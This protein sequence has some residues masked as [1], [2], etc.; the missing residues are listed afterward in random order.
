MLPFE[1]FTPLGGRLQAA[2]VQRVLEKRTQAQLV[3]K[4]LVP[5]GK[6]VGLDDVGG[7]KAFGRRALDRRFGMEHD[8]VVKIRMLLRAPHD[9]QPLE[10]YAQHL[11]MA[12]ALLDRRRDAKAGVFV[13]GGEFPPLV[14]HQV[15]GIVFGFE[16]VQVAGPGKDQ[17]VDLR[18]LAIDHKTQVVQHDM[19]F[20]VLEVVVQIVRRLALTLDAPPGAHEFVA[21]PLLLAQVQRGRAL[22]LLEQHKALG[23]VISRFE[24]HRVFLEA[25][26]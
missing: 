3:Y 21:Q 12:Q 5:G 25:V 20:R 26:F 1:L 9:V 7:V 18:D 22:Q 4:T 24:R 11:F 8:H 17:V 16:Q 23:F 6:L 19:V 14:D 15:T 13:L 2:H 10:E